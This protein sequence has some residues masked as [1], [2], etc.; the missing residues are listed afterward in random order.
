MAFTQGVRRSRALK[1]MHVKVIDDLIP[2]VA[3]IVGLPELVVADIVDHCFSFIKQWMRD[4]FDK[5]YI[6]LHEFGRIAIN[7]GGLRKKT[8]LLIKTYRKL[9]GTGK[10]QEQNAY[11]ELR[12]LWKMR[13]LSLQAQKWRKENNSRLVFEKGKKN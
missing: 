1:R 12:K 9:K 2:Q 13:Q 4:P 7:H 8:A 3:E 5:P 6:L 10:K 11:K